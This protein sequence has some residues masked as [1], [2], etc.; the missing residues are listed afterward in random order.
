MS[1]LLF[2]DSEVFQKERPTGLTD[3]QKQELLLNLAN[4]IIAD[5]FSND[6]PDEIVQDLAQ[7]Y[8]F[9]DEGFDLA[10][11]LK[12]MFDRKASYNFSTLFCEHLE[13]FNSDV[14]E[15]HRK[16]VKEWVCA[17][18]PVLK[19][20]VGSELMV[21]VDALGRKFKNG[22]ILYVNEINDDMA[23]YY[24]SS[25]K[26]DTTNMIFDCERLESTC[27]ENKA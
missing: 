16:N 8:P 15:I 11:E 20:A 6:D 5:G 4:G 13:F 19:F 23:Q 25:V 26:N 27:K 9:N 21:T 12:E 10:I 17:H 2:N 22:D 7:L 18:K 14:D 1:N 24:V 3:A